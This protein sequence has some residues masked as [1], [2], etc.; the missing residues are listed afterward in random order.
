M[1]EGTAVFYVYPCCS[2]HGTEVDLNV[3]CSQC[4]YKHLEPRVA[5]LSYGSNAELNMKY[6]FVNEEDA[7][8]AKAN[9]LIKIQNK[10]KNTI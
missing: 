1:N 7:K 9:L 6:V 8:I 2:V 5:R 10:Q 4:G 3:G